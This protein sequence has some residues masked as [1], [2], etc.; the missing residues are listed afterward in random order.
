[1]KLSVDEQREKL[2]E[3]YNVDSN[4]PSEAYNN[5]H[6][7]NAFVNDLIKNGL[8]KEHFKPELNNNKIVE[9]FKI[10]KDGYCYK[11]KF[12]SESFFIIT[13]KLLR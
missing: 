12:I 7:L 2:K 10:L 3:Y 1:M 4:Y 13:R 5:T 11:I 6:C 8:I 9:Y